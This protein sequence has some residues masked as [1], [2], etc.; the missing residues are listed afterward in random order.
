MRVGSNPT[1]CNFLDILQLTQFTNVINPRRVPNLRILFK[2]MKFVVVRKP[3]L[4]LLPLKAFPKRLSRSYR[5][6]CRAQSRSLK[7]VVISTVLSGALLWTAPVQAEVLHNNTHLAMDSTSVYFRWLILVKSVPLE[8][9]WREYIRN[10][11]GLF[12]LLEQLR[13]LSLLTSSRTILHGFQQSLVQTRFL[14]PVANVEF[15]KYRIH[16]KQK[17]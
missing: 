5:L 10:T 8:P 6:K 7:S 16:P 4:R 17:R 11:F 12:S 2:K 13:C 14:Q 1:L 15:N 3:T 9:Q